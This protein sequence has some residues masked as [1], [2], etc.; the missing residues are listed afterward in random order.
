MDGEKDQM[1]TCMGWG[2]GSIRDIKTVFLSRAHLTITSSR[3]S[4]V[5]HEIEGHGTMGHPTSF[6][7]QYYN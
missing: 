1:K 5:Q 6:K 7:S 4:M 3:Y 2:R